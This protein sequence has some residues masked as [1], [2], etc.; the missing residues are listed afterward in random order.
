[1]G[2]ESKVVKEIEMYFVL[3]VYESICESIFH[4]PP[5]GSLGWFLPQESIHII[6]RKLSNSKRG[7]RCFLSNFHFIGTKVNQAFSGVLDTSMTKMRIED[8]LT[9]FIGF[10]YK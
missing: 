2:G 4:P 10:S 8:S 6:L 1:M 9:Q 5:F 3:S 7:R